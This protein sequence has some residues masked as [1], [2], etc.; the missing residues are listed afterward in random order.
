VVLRDATP[1]V[2]AGSAAATVR[3]LWCVS[4]TGGIPVGAVRASARETCAET[5]GLDGQRLTMP[6]AEDH[7]AHLV[8][9]VVALEAGE[10]RIDGAD[11]T[12]SAGLRRGSQASG[13]VVK[14][15]AS[16]KG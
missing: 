13:V 7:F 5:P 12:Y 11:V 6:N 1:R 2:A 10:V 8:V 9:E 14:I 3:V 16:D 15:T 4:P